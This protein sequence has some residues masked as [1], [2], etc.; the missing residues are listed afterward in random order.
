MFV[1]GISVVVVV[2][3]VVAAAA[4]AAMVIYRICIRINRTVCGLI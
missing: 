4:A 2:V 3:V 1:E